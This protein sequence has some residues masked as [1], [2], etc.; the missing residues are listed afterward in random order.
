MLEGYMSVKHKGIDGVAIGEEPVP[1]CGPGHITD[2]LRLPSLSGLFQH[3]VP[4]LD[5]PLRFVIALQ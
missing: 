3:E 4:A 1:L 2:V 5:V